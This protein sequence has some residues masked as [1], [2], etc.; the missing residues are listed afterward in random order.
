MK[1]DIEQFTDRIVGLPP[2]ERAKMFAFLATLQ[3]SDNTS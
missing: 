1:W 3:K 2:A